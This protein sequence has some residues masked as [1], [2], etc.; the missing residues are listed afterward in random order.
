MRI[1]IVRTVPR[2]YTRCLIQLHQ[3]L[4]SSPIAEWAVVRTVLH[5][6]MSTNSSAFEKYLLT[7]LANDLVSLDFQKTSRRLSCGLGNVD[8]EIWHSEDFW[9]DCIFVLSKLF[10]MNTEQ[11]PF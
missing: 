11:F 2:F 5:I 4:I 9:K 7:I 1:Q 3:V 8:G 6:H 10:L